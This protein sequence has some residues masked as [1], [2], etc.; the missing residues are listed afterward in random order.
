MNSNELASFNQNRK[1]FQVGFA[2]DNLEEAMSRWTELYKIGPWRVSVL[3]SETIPD[4]IRNK[5][6]VTPDVSYRMAT[7]MVGNLQFEL[8]E[9]NET[10]P[11][12]SDFLRDRGV[13]IHHI[14][15]RIPEDQMPVELERYAGLDIP[16]L[17]GGH[18]RNASFYYMDTT[19][20]LGGALIELGNCEP[21]VPAP[22]EPAKEQ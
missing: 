20:A 16:V 8:M 18:F 7:T 10:T 13:G 1:I 15:E 5:G 2:V 22:D 19:D 21:L 3:S 12:Y 11:I 17:Y 9:A 14:K 4:L 6:A